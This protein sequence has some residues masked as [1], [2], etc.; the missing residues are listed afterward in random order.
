VI[1]NQIRHASRHA[2]YLWRVVGLDTAQLAT[3]SEVD[4]VAL[5][6]GLGFERVRVFTSKPII[7]LNE[8]GVSPQLAEACVP[9]QV[10]DYAY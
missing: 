1:P 2:V 3:N 8:M 9:I 7:P 4:Q 10:V 6:T 5:A